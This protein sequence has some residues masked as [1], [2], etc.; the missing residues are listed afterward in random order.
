MQDV[1]EFSKLYSIPIPYEPEWEYYLFVLAQ[2]ESYRHLPKLVEAYKDLER[3][4]Q[5]R[6][7]TVAQYKKMVLE[8]MVNFI[9]ST[10]AYQNVNEVQLVSYPISKKW[11][12]LSGY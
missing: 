5:S 3:Y 2:H 12:L 1:K 7:L 6:D 11:N 9:K 8:H 4:V 10:I